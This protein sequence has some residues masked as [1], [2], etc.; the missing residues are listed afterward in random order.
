MIQLKNFSIGFG[1]KRLLEDFNTLF[2]SHK[3]TSLIGRNGSGKSTLMK[4]ICK[5][6]DK[7]S[8]EILI[9]GENIKNIPRHILASKLSYVNTHRPGMGNL[10]CIDVIRL[11]RSPYTDWHGRLSSHDDTSVENALS[12][13][14]MKEYAHR[15]F[16]TLSD[17]ESQKIMIARAIAQDTDIIL[18]DE[19]TSFLDLPTRYELVSLLK[20]LTEEE[21]KTILFSTHELDIALKLS[22]NIALLDNPDFINL[23]KEKMVEYLINTHHPFSHFLS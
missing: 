19:P 10:K 22:D 12:L 20:K 5:L 2:P 18:L 9:N 17:G 21:G 6:N 1:H 15:Y 14:G 7:Y 13:V 23:P 4:A 16:H 3:L 11:G 8:G